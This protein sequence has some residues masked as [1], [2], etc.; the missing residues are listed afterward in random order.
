MHDVYAYGVI[1]PSTLVELGGAFPTEAG[2]G[3][4]AAVHPSLGGEAAGSAYVLGRLGVPTKLTGTMLGDDPE[5]RRVVEL[6]AG[7]GVDTGAIDT[8][9]RAVTEIVVSTGVERTVFGDYG[10]MLDEQAWSAPSRIDIESA[11][12]VCLD[13]FFGEDSLQATRWCREASV[14]YVTVD[15]EPGSEI[16]RH[17]AAVIVA[18]EFASRDPEYATFSAYADRCEGLVVLTRGAGDLLYGRAGAPPQAFPPFDVETRDATG[19]G[20]A[21]RAGL[22]YG[23]LAGQGDEELVRTAS[24]VAALVCQTVPGVVNGPTASDLARFLDP[25]G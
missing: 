16:A 25:P 15:V 9:G 11:R 21:F 10:R 20:D 19:A 3:E 24:A 8:T 1:A 12:V 18:G 5:S 22:I 6:L 7:E 13:P 17:A 14:P 4:I 23:M 2:Y